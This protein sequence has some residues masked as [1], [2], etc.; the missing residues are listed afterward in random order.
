METPGCIGMFMNDLRFAFRQ[1]HRRPGFAFAVI[2]TLALAVGVNTA[3]F[4]IVD[5]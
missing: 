5:G 3:V 4:S 1:L 2:L